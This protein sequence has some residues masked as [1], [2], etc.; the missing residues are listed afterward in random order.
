MLWPY[1]GSNS[2]P[3]FGNLAKIQNAII[4]GIKASYI[5]VRPKI[6]VHSD[7]GASRQSMQYFFGSLFTSGLAPSSVDILGLTWYPFYEYGDTQASALDSFTY[8]AQSFGLPLHVVETNWPLQCSNPSSMRFAIDLNINQ[9]DPNAIPF[10]SDG[11]KTWLYMISETLSKVPNGL[12]QGLF[13]W[14]SGWSNLTSLGTSCEQNTMIQD[15]WYSYDATAYG[16]Y[17]PECLCAQSINA[18]ADL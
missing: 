18:F 14:E 4:A 11:Q 5:P 8:L 1:G 16:Q 7:Q 12:G 9:S 13:Y 3:N 15:Y 6:M 2:G 17:A 10:T